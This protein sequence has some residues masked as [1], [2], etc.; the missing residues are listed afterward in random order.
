MPT[1]Y[2]PATSRTFGVEFE[3]D[4]SRCRNHSD[5]VR[6]L[7]A[8][9][10]DATIAG[11]RDTAY[12]V[13]QVKQDVSVHGTCPVEIVSP[14]LDWADPAAVTD[15]FARLARAFEAMGVRVNDSCG[16][17]V[18]MYVRDLTGP[19]IG[20]LVRRYANRQR[21]I[22][23]LAGRGPNRYCRAVPRGDAD[24]YAAMVETRC[25]PGY[26]RYVTINP[27]HY[28]TRGTLE[29]RQGAGRATPEA[30]L[31][32]VGFLVGL[33]EAA[34]TD[35]DI[36]VPNG[37]PVETHLTAMV[38][39]DLLAPHLARW[40]A[41]DMSTETLADLASEAVNQATDAVRAALPNLFRLQGLA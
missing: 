20:A 34:R 23:L 30:M 41:G 2:T 4:A 8:A 35:A 19:Q 14:V 38:E 40:V 36:T 13:W 21:T 22:D 10:L 3:V 16:G 7:R 26:D 17:H 9:G 29:F 18:H 28:A 12:T 27:A 1:T 37:S 39:A 25:F 24:A 31:G 5:V 15:A 11:C 6:H 32:W 33:V